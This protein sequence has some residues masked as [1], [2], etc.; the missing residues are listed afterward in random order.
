MDTIVNSL[1]DSVL[2]KNIKLADIE[3]I[4]ILLNYSVKTYKK[5]ELIFGVE[6]EANYVGIILD[7]SIRV[8]KDLASGRI[9]TLLDKTK[10]DLFGEGS[11]FSDTL[12]YPSNIFSAE[13]SKI[14]LISKQSLNNLISSDSILLHNLLRSLA[15]RVLMLNLKTELLSYSSI[16]KKIAFSL[17]F[18]M[19]KSKV[20]NTVNL[21][22]SKKDWSE[23]LNTSRPSLCR[24]LG[25]LSKQRIL[26]VEGR[27]ILI[28]KEQ[29]LLEILHT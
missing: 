13:T 20:Q 1:Y 23:H 2:F 12:N 21:P 19:D 14:L 15:N 5:N 8:Q 9:V 29:S 26:L 11:V 16:Q 28:L 10:G 24:E 7:G 27:E 4:L 3:K 17:L 22:F 6:H 25:V 18:L